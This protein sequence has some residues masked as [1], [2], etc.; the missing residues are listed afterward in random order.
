MVKQGRYKQSGE[1]S[2]KHVHVSENRH[3]GNKSKSDR[4]RHVPSRQAEDK[5]VKSSAE[6]EDRKSVV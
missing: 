5:C 4:G 1:Q 6:K 2:K 3:T